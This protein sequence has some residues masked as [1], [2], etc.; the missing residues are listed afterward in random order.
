VAA[1]MTFGLAVQAFYGVKIDNPPFLMARV[2]EDGPGRAYLAASCKEKGWAICAYR[3]RPLTDANRILWDPDP[4][5]GV[6]FPADYETRRRMNAEEKAFVLGSTLQS[7]GA[8]TAAALR[9]GLAQLALVRPTPELAATRQIWR[10]S[11]LREVLPNAPY[12]AARA[13]RGTFPLAFFDA[14]SLIAL[15]AALAFLAWRLTRADMRRREGEAERLFLCLALA[16]LATVAA[17][18]LVCGAASGPSPRY[19][20]RLIWLI[21]LLALIGAARFGLGPRRSR[22]R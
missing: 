22:E 1:I 16:L 15:A 20:T 9:N 4:A 11:L 3:D 19:Q 12:L 2:L 17:N 13:Y 8:Q 21:P 14:T 10:E 7:P 6:F 18:A 5:T